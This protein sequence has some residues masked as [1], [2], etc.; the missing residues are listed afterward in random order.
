MAD[1]TF[2]EYEGARL[3]RRALAGM[4][5]S[6]LS[7]DAG[8]ASFEDAARALLGDDNDQTGAYDVAV[9]IVAARLEGK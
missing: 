7:T 2:A 1:E 9:R 4:D 6:F 5:E 8:Y 3:A